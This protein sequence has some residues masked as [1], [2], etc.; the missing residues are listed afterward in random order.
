MNADSASGLSR[1]QL[2]TST[3]GAGSALLLSACGG[4]SGS[5]S[6]DPAIDFVNWVSAEEATRDNFNKVLTAFGAEHADIKMRNVPVPFEQM[7]QQLLTSIAGGN[8][9]ETTMLSHSWPFELGP[10]KG[11]L[12]LWDIAGKDYLEKNF[13]PQALQAGEYEGKLYA[14]PVSIGNHG[15]W[16]NKK[17]MAQAGLDP[18]SPPKTMAELDS[19][20]AE[21][22]AAL[23]KDVF[24][25]ALD[26]TKANGALTHFWIWLRTF[27]A[28][29]LYDGKVNFDTTEVGDTLNWL[30][31]LV[32]K[33]YC[34]KGQGI[35]EERELMAK[36]RIVFRTDGPF[37][38]GISRAVNSALAGNAFHDTF[39]VG[40]MPVG[41]YGKPVTIANLHQAGITPA[42]DP[43]KAWEWIKFFAT[44]DVSIAEYQRPQGVIP[45][46]LPA[47][48]L[49]E[50][51]ADPA[52][53]AFVE[54]VIP[55]MEPAPFSPAYGPAQEPIVNAMQQAALTD[56]PI[57][58]ILADTESALSR[59]YG[60]G[61]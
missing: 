33:G 5:G 60:T 22:K 23:G 46:Y 20:M 32:T 61:G 16:R 35:R 4:N 21:L 41:A 15:F 57:K 7:R 38:M 59:V 11:L 2:L 45:A 53:K 8:A 52:S 1:R 28:K 3:L 47:A 51:V 12:D 49:P 9:P 54:E 31:A 24:P 13:F 27:G 25:F 37:W 50:T 17:L 18:D 40:A 29:P 19:Q 26:L 48:K 10:K 30:R 34:P 6:G 42:A 58:T 43:K 44:S 55:T 39:A 36:D 56:T 14:L